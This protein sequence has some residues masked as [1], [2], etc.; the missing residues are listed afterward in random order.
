MVA[1]DIV[2]CGEIGSQI[3][4]NKY[5]FINTFVSKLHADPKPMH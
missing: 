2:N 5:M 1:W 3:Y 4:R